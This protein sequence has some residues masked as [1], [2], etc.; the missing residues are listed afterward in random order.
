MIDRDHELPVKRQ[1]ELL[2]ISR[3]TVYYH[4][5][6]ISE[7]EQALM[8]RIDELHLE[9]PFAGSRML[10]GLLRLQGIEVS[11]RHVG[12]L[13]RR[14][15][16]ETLYR[17][18]DTSRKHPAHPVF[19]YLLREAAIDRANA[20][21]ALDITYIPMERGWVYLVAVLDWASRR[22]LAHRVSITMEADF[23]VEALREAAARWGAPEIVNT[24]QGSQFSGAEFVAEVKR[25]GARQSM[26]SRGCWRDN[27]FVERLWRS[28]KYEE[29]YLKAYD[30]VGAA[31][32]GLA[33]Y[34]DFYNARRPHQCHDGRTP[35]MVYF[36]ATAPV[37]AA[38]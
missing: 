3:G 25:I 21:W 16:I 37:V 18:P 11:R 5:E 2:G 4:A 24:D 6:P 34:F 9:H 36:D 32:Q 7:A 17:K 30:S 33:A 28:V 23:C 12:T 10:R 26:D 20:A 13:M 29:V 1:A 31:R 22:V 15:G 19:Q 14:M 35:D 27:V 8:R 38:A